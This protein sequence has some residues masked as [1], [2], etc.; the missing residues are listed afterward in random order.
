MLCGGKRI[1]QINFWPSR[2]EIPGLPISNILWHLDNNERSADCDAW[3]PWCN[4][5]T[6]FGNAIATFG[7]YI[8]A[9]SKVFPPP[10]L[11]GFVTVHL[12]KVTV[13]PFCIIPSQSS[14][15]LG[16]KEKSMYKD[17]N[18]RASS[19][20]WSLLN[21]YENNHDDA[22]YNGYDDACNDYDDAYNDYDDD[23]YDDDGY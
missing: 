17:F 3:Q 23:G 20:R 11:L 12:V 7:I 6:A 16:L 2:Q 22:A 5:P 18:V 10:G 9:S 13:F 19:M 8:R 21:M 15:P 4:V 14:G 1:L